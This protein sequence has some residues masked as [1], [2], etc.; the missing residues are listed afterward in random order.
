MDK[1]GYLVAYDYELLKQSLPTVYAHVNKIVLA[2]DKERKSYIGET[3]T[4]D[5]SF[6]DWIKAFDTEN[7]IQFYEDNFYVPG[8]GAR[9]AE[10]RERNMLAKFMGEGGWHIQIDVD[11]YF[12]DFKKIVE[13]LKASEEKFKGRNVT[14]RVYWMSIF[15]TDSNGFFLV[16]ESREN[17]A[18]ATNYPHYEE[19]RYNHANENVVFNHV[20]LHQSWGRTEADLAKKLRN[21]SHTEDFDT[22]S[23]FRFWKSIDVDNHKY[24]RDF[25]PL[26]GSNWKRLKYLEANSISELLKKMPAHLE[27]PAPTK[28]HPLQRWLP[29]VIY[30]RLVK[31]N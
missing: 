17:F 25:H 22:E 12:V 5:P 14:V 30:N 26:F 31:S 16:D 10:T 9:E 4:I 13:E 6:F 3:F 20:A 19:A 11:E 27:T 21:W 23:Y 7:K 28:A 2:I 15:K 29:P 8:L 18:L 24:V 1:V